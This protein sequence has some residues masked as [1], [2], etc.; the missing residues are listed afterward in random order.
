MK[1]LT[2]IG[3]LGADAEAHREAGREFISMSIADTTIRKK[4]DGTTVETTEWITATYNGNHDNLLP[5]LKKG[6]KV[7]AIGECATRLFSSKKDRC[8]KAGLNLYIREIQLL[9]GSPDT[10]PSR[11]YDSDGVERPVQKYFYAGATKDGMLYD[12]RGV[13]YN[14]TPEGWVIANQQP[15]D[16]PQDTQV[17]DDGTT[18]VNAA[19][20]ATDSQ[21]VSD[22]AP[23]TPQ[24]RLQADAEST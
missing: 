4:E 16:Q 10:I 18:I 15:K 9:G 20:V 24:Y 13:A 8:M 23:F 17:A 7:V 19:D 6:Q 5:Y 3:N 21:P 1:Y 2:L 12:R 11:L 22:D 14:V